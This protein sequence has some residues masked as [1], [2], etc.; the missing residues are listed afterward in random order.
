MM[1]KRFNKEDGIGIVTALMVAFIVFSLGAVW[2]SVSTHELDETTYDRNRTTALHVADAGVR[3]AMYELSQTTLKND[4]F[5]TGNGTGAGGAC[6]LENVTTIQ[7]GVTRQLGQYWTEVADATPANPN[8]HRYFIEAWGWA[9][10]TNSRQL[11]VRKV[12]QEVE[13]VIKRGFVYALFAASGGVSAGNQKTIYG[14]IYSAADVTISNHTELWANDAGFQGDGDL[15]TAGQLWIP[16]GSN[17]TIEGD[18]LAG[19]HLQDDNPGSAYGGDATVAAGDAFFQ[20]ATV[21]GKVSL[22]GTVVPGSDLTAG[23]LGENLVTLDPVSVDPLPD[24]DWTKITTVYG[25]PHSIDGTT[26]ATG[27]VFLWSTWGNFDAW[28]KANRSDLFGWHYVEDPGAYTWRLAV[29]GGTTFGDDFMLVFD[30]EMTVDGSSNI[31]PASAPVTV[32]IVG[33]QIT[34]DLQFGKNLSSNDDHRWVMYSKGTVGAKNLATIYGVVYG[35]T[36][37]SVNHLEV[38]FRPPNS[39]LGFIFGSERRVIARPF[40]WREV[41]DDPIPCVLP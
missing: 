34:S 37:N 26:A 35:E 10:D 28:F 29:G 22:F 18:V 5:W 24:F 36:D 39:D 25:G 8:D 27:P 32:S 30:G 19:T 20:K 38:H 14:D 3:Q 33:N 4:P 23:S 1:L 9:R 15:T 41:P 40:V 31:D 16:S 6:Q 7:D 13:I 11:S 2:Y 17:L 21:A 12:E